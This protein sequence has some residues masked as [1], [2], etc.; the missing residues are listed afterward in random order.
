MVSNIDEE[1]TSL[2]SQPAQT[3]TASNPRTWLAF[4]LYAVL[5]AVVC[6]LSSLSCGVGGGTL[7]A[8]V[9]LSLVVPL[10]FLHVYKTG[11]WATL[12]FRML[13]C[14]L[15]AFTIGQIICAVQDGN[16]PTKMTT[17]TTT[18]TT[19]NTPTSMPT[20]TMVPTQNITNSTV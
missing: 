20:S 18:P 9:I 13:A 16:A 2:Q 1:V 8:A 11:Y 19:T 7:D 3:S 4:V 10:I 6:F 14:V 15:L 5:F 17:T 12:T